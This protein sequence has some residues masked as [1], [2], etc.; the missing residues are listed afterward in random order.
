MKPNW[1]ATIV[2][3][4][5]ALVL[6]VLVQ[7][8]LTTASSQSQPNSKPGNCRVESVDY[9]GWDA[10][11]LS[12][13]WVKLIVVPQNG[14]RLMQV[15][16]AGHDYLFVNPKLE[17]K[18]F[19][20]T[21]DKWFNYGGDKIWLLPEGNDDEQHW[22]GNS[23]VI[24]DGPYSFRKISEGKNCEIVL[25]GPADPQTGIQISRKIQ[26]G[27]DSPRIHFN[28]SMKNIW[29]HRRVVD[30]I[31]FAVQHFRPFRFGFQ[32]QLLELYSGE[33]LQ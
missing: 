11:Q 22:R 4:T 20:P 9:K 31:G 14:G 28:A 15:N 3:R 17:G 32:P 25:T 6:L 10:Q 1:H 8:Q 29:P 27:T 26:L 12:N 7:F 2:A 33:L 24:D 30:A 18:Y 21:Q 19:P 5:P 23:D 16:F 13:D